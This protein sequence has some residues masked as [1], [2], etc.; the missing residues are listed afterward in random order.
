MILLKSFL[1]QRKTTTIKYTADADSRY[2]KEKRNS[3]RRDATPTRITPMKK[4][5]KPGPKKNKKVLELK[6]SIGKSKD[7]RKEVKEINDEFCRI[8]AE[9]GEDVVEMAYYILHNQLSRES[10]FVEAKAILNVYQRKTNRATITPR[11]SFSNY[12]VSD[13]STREQQQLSQFLKQNIGSKIFSSREE[14][15]NV[16]DSLLPRATNFQLLE[17][18]TEN[19]LKNYLAPQRPVKPDTAGLDD[20]EVDQL[21]KKFKEDMSSFKSKLIPPRHNTKFPFYR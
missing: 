2:L 3:R 4:K 11:K 13:R 9:K 6:T 1:T 8:S 15:S 16:A 17:K 12:I 20:E 7:V 18:D 21:K 19:V 5:L 10:R 14:I